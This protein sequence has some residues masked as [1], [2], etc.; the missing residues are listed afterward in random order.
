MFTITEY[1]TTFNKCT[2]FVVFEFSAM[3]TGWYGTASTL[4]AKHEVNIAKLILTKKIQNNCPMVTIMPLKGKGNSR[5]L[6]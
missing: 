3:T 5:I 2:R 1:R 4:S 6:I